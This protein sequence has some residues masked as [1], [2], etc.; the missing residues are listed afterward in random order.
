[1]GHAGHEV[2]N[3]NVAKYLQVRDFTPDSLSAACLLHWGVYWQSNAEMDSA[4]E[5]CVN[6]ARAVCGPK[7]AVT[8]VLVH[9]LSRTQ[10]ARPSSPDRPGCRQPQTAT[11]GL[12]VAVAWRPQRG[13]PSS[14][15]SRGF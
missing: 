11:E 2:A 3:V 6:T 4:R 5:K 1:M 9:G 14:R 7:S 15:D 12:G 8:V 10:T 13:T